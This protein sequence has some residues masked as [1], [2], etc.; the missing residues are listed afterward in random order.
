MDTVHTYS[1]PCLWN[2]TEKCC[3]DQIARVNA[4]K[5]IESLI[6]LLK[7]GTD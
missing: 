6:S 7:H 2:T 5:E 3:Y 4:W 1:F